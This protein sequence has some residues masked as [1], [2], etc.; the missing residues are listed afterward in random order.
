MVDGPTGTT[1]PLAPTIEF[2][3]PRNAST[4][5]IDDTDPVATELQLG[6]FDN[7]FEFVSATNGRFLDSV[8]ESDNWVGGDSR[9][10]YLRVVDAGAKGRKFLEADVEWWTSFANNNNRDHAAHEVEDDPPSKL[11]LFEVAGKPGVFVSRGLTIVCD[12][13]DRGLKT[14]S[15]IAAGHP[16]FAK[17]GGVRGDNQSNYRIRRGGMHSFAA[18][19]YTPKG[20]GASFKSSP[21]PV[22]SRGSQRLMPLQVYIVRASR[23]GAPSVDPTAVFTFDLPAA[24]ET[25]ARIG[26]WL[27]TFVSASDA[28]K[29]GVSVVRASSGLPYTVAVVDPPPGVKVDSVGGDEEFQLAKALPGEQNVLRLF[30]VPSLA[31]GDAG[32]SYFPNARPVLLGSTTPIKAAPELIGASFISATAGRGVYT[33]AH[34][35][36]HVLTDKPLDQNDGHYT[37]QLATQP[38]APGSL[39]LM[40]PVAAMVGRSVIQEKRLWMVLDPGL[41]T[42]TGAPQFQ[43]MAI[44][45]SGFLI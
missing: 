32:E 12:D 40:S 30:F 16:L 14:N 13:E 36:G 35:L 19:A 1:A 7:F 21:V 38:R 37:E 41:K 42:A 39:N 25:Y 11:S 4:F 31:S 22:F 17:H 28:A 34:E 8:S 2:V 15:G 44:L 5:A 26:I 18:A 29:P 33:S 6:L 10:F 24:T 9:R 23:G 3:K 43:I 20:A 45:G 27:W